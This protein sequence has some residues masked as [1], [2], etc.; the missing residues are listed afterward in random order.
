MGL[1]KSAER[2]TFQRDA[3]IKR[4]EEEGK[5]PRPEIIEMY[6]AWAETK[7]EHEADPEWQKGNMEFDMR[8]SE[9]MLDKVRSDMVYAQHL[10][11][12]LCNNE[13]QQLDTWPIL[14]GETWSCSWRYAGGIIA[15]M[16]QQ[17]DYMDWYCSGIRSND[18]TEEEYAGMTEEQQAYHK[19]TRAYVG[20]G[21]VSEEIREDLQKL[22]WTVLDNEDRI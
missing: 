11:A 19:Q 8:T 13:F 16:Q 15:D 22:G 4:C 10:Y 14:K 5:Q 7:Q 21:Q 9:W 20:E 12:A 3:Y 18:V 1:S 2:G 17:G 6:D